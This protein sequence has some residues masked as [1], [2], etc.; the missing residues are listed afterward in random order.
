MELYNELTD[1]T[2]V[3]QTP[4]EEVAIPT[5]AEIEP[6]NEKPASIPAAL[7]EES[8]DDTPPAAPM[9]AEAPSS[10]PVRR[11]ITP[12]EPI[13]T[14][15]SRSTVENEDAR[16]ASAWHEIHNA[17][18]TRRILSG[19]LGGIEQTAGG[20]TIATVE[21]KNCWMLVKRYLL[22]ALFCRMKFPMYIFLW[23]KGFLGEGKN[24]LSRQDFHILYSQGI[25]YTGTLPGKYGNLF[26]K[27][28]QD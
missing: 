13:L 20:K 3:K 8:P 11:K 28:K 5:S 15:D 1:L 26:Y 14:I 10:A 6:D 24:Y 4:D 9:V 19:H 7:L 2:L 21:Y 16:E 23:L 12:A 18:R 17:Y 25:L 22:I 27:T